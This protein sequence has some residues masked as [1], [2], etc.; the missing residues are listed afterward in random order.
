M[1]TTP[2]A[3]AIGGY[4]TTVYPKVSTANGLTNAICNYI[5]WSGGIGNRIN[6]MGRL[7]EGTEKTESG[8]IFT[9][10]K[11]IKSS[12]LKGTADIIATLQNGKTW[13][14]EIKVGNDKPRPEQIKMQ[15]RVR[16]TGSHYDFISD[17]AQ[18]F[19]LYDRLIT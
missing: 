7:V 9:K 16:K 6:V 2:N 5:N 14:I 19:T 8:A 4:V 10:K 18:F 11:F 1:E 12:T 13:H 3:V 17:M 15:E